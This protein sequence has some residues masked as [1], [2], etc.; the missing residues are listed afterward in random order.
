[1]LFFARGSAR[2]EQLERL[3]E[4]ALNNIRAA[5]AWPRAPS[6]TR[7]KQPVNSVASAGGRFATQN[8]GSLWRLS[9]WGK[10]NGFEILTE[11]YDADAQSV[12]SYSSRIRDGFLGKGK[13]QDCLRGM[14]Q[15]VQPGCF[16][17]CRLC[18]EESA[19]GA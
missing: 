14:V 12:C 13:C 11:A 16:L 8:H 4:I 1:V 19:V 5:M 2:A 18:A 7:A 17:H 6:R 3:G 15:Q 9:K 10:L